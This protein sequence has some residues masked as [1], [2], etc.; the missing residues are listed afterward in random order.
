MIALEPDPALGN[1]GLGR[2]A[3]CFLDSMAY[4][5]IPAIGYGIRYEYGMFRQELADGWQV[6]KPEDWLADSNPWEF[7][8]SEATYRV[9]FGGRVEH[10]HHRA[11]WEGTEDVLAVAH[12]VLI[13]A[14]GGGAVNTLRL[15]G[16]KPAEAL[17]IPTFNRG[18][19]RGA[20]RRMRS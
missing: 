12:D 15:W 3:A 10:R 9:Q 7:H 1:G 2:L 17:D 20:A 6:E 11:H 18:F 5:G 4:L 13:P 16:A 8:R 19:H 14:H